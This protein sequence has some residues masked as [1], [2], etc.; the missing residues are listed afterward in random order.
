LRAGRSVLRTSEPS[1]GPVGELIKYLF[2]GKVPLP[3][4]PNVR[5]Q[6]F[7]YLFAADRFEHLHNPTT[8]VLK[9]VSEGIDVV[10]TRYLFSSLAYNAEN[11]EGEALVQ[12]LNV[13]F[14]APDALI[15]LKCDVDL[16]IR[17]LTQSRPALDTYENRDKLVSVERN[18]ERIIGDY[19][20]RKL[21][22]DASLSR[23]AIANRVFDFVRHTQGS[24]ADCSAVSS[25]LNYLGASPLQNSK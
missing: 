2:S 24:L 23:E 15:F 3:P 20:G 5:D 4:D 8:G 9:Q 11:P 18:Y 19:S 16:S 7:A 13:D 22:V 25:A 10:S 6:Q 12:R 17:R 21:V 14:P 1:P